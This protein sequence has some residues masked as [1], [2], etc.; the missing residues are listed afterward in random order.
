MGDN[1]ERKH[2]VL[3]HG[4]GHGAWSWFKMKPLLEGA[5]HRVTAV[6]LSASG[7]NCSKRLED[8]HTLHDYS[9]PLLEI[10]KAASSI[11]D[12]KIVLVGHSYGGINMALAMD[13]YPEKVSVAV[14]VSALMPDAI[15]APSYVLDEVI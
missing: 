5:G 11:D 6:N 14:Y 1:K 9:T 3:V 7:T 8:L 13:E 10:M 4:V 15:H 2:F 12:E